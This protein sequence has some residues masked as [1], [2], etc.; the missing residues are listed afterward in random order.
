M[1]IYV[2]GNPIL[3]K[4]SLP[5][6]L[7]PKLR[8]ELPEVTF[9][10]AD[11][12]ENWWQPASTRLDSARLAQRG[13]GEKELVIMDTVQGIEK[14]TVF[15]SLAEFEKTSRIT[16]HDYDVYVDLK[17]M[18]KVGKVKKATIIG[19]PY[20]NTSLKNILKEIKK[21]LE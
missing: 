16:P 1:N 10:H 6:R 18:Q 13:E 14:V 11:P 9:I 8:K 5:A 17:L 15:N 7:L 3:K 20:G 19:I 12:T 21:S 4:D 2:F